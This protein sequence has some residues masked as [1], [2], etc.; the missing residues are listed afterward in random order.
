MCL[1]SV[2]L[3]G[4]YDSMLTVLSTLL[5]P[6]TRGYAGLTVPIAPFLWSRRDGVILFLEVDLCDGVT[7]DVGQTELN[8]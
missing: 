1:T 5:T 3:A 4:F 7:S 2:V 6:T 8:E